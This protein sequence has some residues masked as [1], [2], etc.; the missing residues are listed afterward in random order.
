MTGRIM[1]VGTT[2]DLD[3]PTTDA[4]LATPAGAV[5]GGVVLIHEIWGLQAHTR[6]V[7]DRFA[8]AGFAV[9][10]PDLL[11]HAGIDA[12]VGAELQRLSFDAPEAERVAAQPRLR[13]AFS[14]SRSPE[15]AV[16]ALRVLRHAVDR[17]AAQP[18]VDGRVAVVGFC[19]GGTYA[20]QLAAADRRV[21]AAVPFYGS[22]PDDDT[23]ARIDAP[24]LAFYGSADTRLMDGL[25]ALE[26]AA[27]AAGV[28]LTPV[29]YEGC[30]HAFF[31]DT[32]ATTY[33]AR[34]AQDAWA[35]TIGFLD[36]AFA[37]PA[38]D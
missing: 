10:A 25:P 35:R 29:V 5:R 9:V 13:E 8:A 21:R 27:A 32:N 17:L 18:D 37:G 20:F 33:D 3:G 14:A 6:D 36:A 1:Q 15:Y 28:D 22:A 2:D 23:L 7:A 12:E 38:A 11:T 24:V 4:Y 19:F 30:R 31:N 26:H 16:W 34:A